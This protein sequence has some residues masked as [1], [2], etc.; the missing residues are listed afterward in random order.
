MRQGIFNYKDGTKKEEIQFAS[1]NLHKGTD[2]T[3]SFDDVPKEDK[4]LYNYVKSWRAEDWKQKPNNTELKN[5]L[6]K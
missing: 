5:N 6:T 3:Y 1:K 2:T 4:E